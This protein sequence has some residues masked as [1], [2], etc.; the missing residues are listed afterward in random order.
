MS[1]PAAPTDEE[2]LT[3]AETAYT[4]KAVLRASA[5]ECLRAALAAARPMIEAQVRAQYAEWERTRKDV[6]FGH[7]PYCGCGPGGHFPN[8]RSAGVS[9]CRSA[10]ISE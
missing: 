8:C 4:R 2:I 7:C 10:G 1:R 6:K 3:A 9:D 5:I